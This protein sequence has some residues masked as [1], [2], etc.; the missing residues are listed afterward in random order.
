VTGQ[1]APTPLCTGAGAMPPVVLS[2]TVGTCPVCGALVRCRTGRVARH[3][4]GHSTRRPTRRNP[5][6]MVK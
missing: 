4:P 1:C 2:P 5:R 3:E 6:V